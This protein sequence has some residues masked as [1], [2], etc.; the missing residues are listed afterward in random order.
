MTQRCRKKPPGPGR[1]GFF[2]DGFE[3]NGVYVKQRTELAC[4]PP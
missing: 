4:L 3:K 2:I 1:G